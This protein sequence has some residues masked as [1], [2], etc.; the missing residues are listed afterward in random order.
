[1]VR[2]IFL[3]LFVLSSSI[4]VFALDDRGNPNDPNVNERANACY[5][6]GSLAGKCNTDWEWEAGWYLIRFE[7]GLISRENFP[8]QFAI[9]LPPLPVEEAAGTEEPVVTG[10]MNCQYRGSGQYI[11]FGAGNYLPA[12]SP[13]YNDALC[14]V[15][16]GTTGFGQAYT[17]GTP[18]NADVI[19]AANNPG[20]VADRDFI[21]GNVYICELA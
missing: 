11:N 8:A 21:I 5:E 15:S 12:G 17:T 7:A 6:N 13:V 16:V 20:T 1:M 4:L 2:K 9:L 18:A 10:P 3:L 19:C 14:L